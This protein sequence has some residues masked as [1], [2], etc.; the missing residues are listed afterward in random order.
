MLFDVYI[1]QALLPYDVFSKFQLSLFEY[2]CLHVCTFVLR[3]VSEDVKAV[4]IV[5]VPA[6]LDA[7]RIVRA[8]GR[9]VVFFPPH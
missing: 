7:D 8:D 1:F 3:V 6:Q 5:S 9:I 2:K 4:L